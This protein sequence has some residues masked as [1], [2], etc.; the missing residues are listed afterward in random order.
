[1]NQLA[2]CPACNRHILTQETVCPFC[3]A[4]LPEAFRAQPSPPRFAGRLSRAAML[5]ASATALLTGA[6]CGSGTASPDTGVVVDGGDGGAVA[7][8]GAPAPDGGGPAPL[9]GAAPEYGA[10]PPLES[11]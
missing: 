4:A 7:A 1:M 5:A 10:P 6:G 8:Y 9:Y 11:E 3:A 2:P